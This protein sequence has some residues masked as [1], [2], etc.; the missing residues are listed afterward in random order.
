MNLSLRDYVEIS[1]TSALIFGVG[2]FFK[3]LNVYCP[4]HFA[5]QKRL[6]TEYV[7]TKSVPFQSVRNSSDVDIKMSEIEAYR[8]S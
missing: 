2:L 1:S 8:V 4:N 6:K 7:D 5:T 3:P